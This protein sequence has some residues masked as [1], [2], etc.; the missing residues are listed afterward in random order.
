[1][2]FAEDI[3]RTIDRFS[4]ELDR[5]GVEW[6]VGGSIASSMYAEPRSTN[7]IDFIAALRPAHAA[8]LAR[9]LEAEFYID[10][11]TAL[12][13][14]LRHRSFNLI[15]ERTFV[16]VDV[17]VPPPGPLGA[18]QLHRRVRVEIDEG[19]YCYILGREDTALQKLRWYRLGDCS[20]DRQWRD[21]QG[22]LDRR[23]GLDLEYL[24]RVAASGDLGELLERALA[25][26]ATAPT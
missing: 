22:L 6:A 7:D 25:E 14:I 1:M 10:E 11:A 15:D 16:K 19:L 12:D 21:I 8:A 3:L 23:E 26:S 9:A 20:S 4:A 5:L 18:D 2:S 24:R 13:A 17:F